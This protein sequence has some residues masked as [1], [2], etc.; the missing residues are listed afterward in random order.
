MK[1][2]NP[3]NEKVV[4]SLRL[5]RSGMVERCHTIPHVGSYNVAQ[6]CYGVATLI[7]SNHPK[8]S[9]DLVKAALWHDATE[10][11]IGDMPSSAKFLYPY[12]RSAIKHAEE[13]GLAVLGLETELKPEDK[14]WLYSCDTVEF[15]LW[16][17]YQQKLGNHFLEHVLE[18]LDQFWRERPLV[19]PMQIL[20]Y[21]IHNYFHDYFIAEDAVNELFE[22]RISSTLT[23]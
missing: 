9:L 19:G 2:E 20:M 21:E 15:Y 8:P 1:T 10:T 22:R 23:D 16:C 18:R 11:V 4:R 7:L 5:M 3:L 14:E 13:E 17:R 12:L 6:H